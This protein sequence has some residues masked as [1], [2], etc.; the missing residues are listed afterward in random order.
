MTITPTSILRLLVLAGVAFQPL[1][2]AAQGTRTP[3]T[4]APATGSAAGRTPGRS[5][6]DRRGSWNEQEY[7]LGPGDKL[8]VE[9]Y[10]QAAAV[11]VAAGPAR[12]QDHAAADRRHRRGRPHVDRA[13]RF[14]DC[15]R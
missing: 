2:A 9:V 3:T 15:R 1:P 4:A 10:R 6:R 12:R 11:A 7:R 14:A 5:D 8:R 13:A